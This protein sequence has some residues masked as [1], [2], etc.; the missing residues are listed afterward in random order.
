MPLRAFH[1]LAWLADQEEAGADSNYLPLVEKTSP[2]RRQFQSSTCPTG[3]PPKTNCK[4]PKIRDNKDLRKKRA[5]VQEMAPTR[6]TRSNKRLAELQQD[7]K[8]TADR[9]EQQQ[10]VD[11]LLTSQ[12]TTTFLSFIR[13][14]CS[15]P[16]VSIY[17]GFVV[18]R[19]IVHPS[20]E[21]IQ[22]FLQPFQKFARRFDSLW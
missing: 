16:N 6:A 15:F 13:I 20:R 8:N 3:A 2:H 18:K 12:R 21:P 1:V 11:R 4:R 22:A 5:R 10:H 19:I 7:E 17:S 14:G 9:S